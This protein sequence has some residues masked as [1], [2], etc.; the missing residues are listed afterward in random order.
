[1]NALRPAPKTYLLTTLINELDD[2]HDQFILVLDDYQFITDESIHDV[3]AE[4]A[5]A[6]PGGLRLVV[7]AR[8][9]P[10]LPLTK[11]RARGDLTEVRAAELRFTESEIRS[12]LAPLLSGDVREEVSIDAGVDTE[13]YNL[14]GARI[15]GWVAGLRLTALALQSGQTLDE[16]LTTLNQGG[17]RFVMEY[18]LTEVLTG[19]PPQVQAFLLRTSILDR[20]RTDLCAD[21]CE[22][23]LG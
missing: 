11:F 15:E 19:Q 1:M 3:L 22:A 2:I 23:K 14:V 5:L 12:F 10:P 9:D 18:L 21:L 7:A 17:G 13:V 6:A 8:S 16:L 4:L 20:L